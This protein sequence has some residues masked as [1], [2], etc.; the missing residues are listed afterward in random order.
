MSEDITIKLIG[1]KGNEIECATLSEVEWILKHDP[2]FSVKV[3]KGE[4]PILM[5]NMLPRDQ[6][7]IEWVLGEIKKALSHVEEGEEEGEEESG[8]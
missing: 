4:R 3:Y 1:L 8:A 7:H 6:G 5:C 2:I